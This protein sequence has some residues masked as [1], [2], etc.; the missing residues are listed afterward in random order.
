LFE[1]HHRSSSGGLRRSA[2]SGS[3]CVPCGG[4]GNHR[5]QGG[6]LVRRRAQPVRW[7]WRRSATPGAHG[8]GVVP[9]GGGTTPRSCRGCAGAGGW[10]RGRL[11]RAESA[12]R[13]ER[14]ALG[15]DRERVSCDW[16]RDLRVWG[17]VSRVWGRVSRDWARTCVIGPG[18][19]VIEGGSRVSGKASRVSGGVSRVIRGASRE[20]GG[21]HGRA[22]CRGQAGSASASNARRRAAALASRGSAR[23]AASAAASEA[24]SGEPTASYAR[25]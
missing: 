15:G 5:H 13:C 23:T 14:V 9:R 1:G 22:E 25:R 18:S 8:L 11:G 21:R 20:I 4:I 12:A 7:G 10:F 17:R 2:L 16:G 24:S 6:T 3:V 19:R